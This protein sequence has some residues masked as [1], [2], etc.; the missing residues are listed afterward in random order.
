MAV[1]VKEIVIRYE[2]TDGGAKPLGANNLEDF[3]PLRLDVHH[4][5]AP[6]PPPE[7]GKKPAR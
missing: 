1:K 5:M 4:H 6:P 7:D 2:E 3:R